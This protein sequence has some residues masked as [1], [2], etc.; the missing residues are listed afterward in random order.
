MLKPMLKMKP[1]RE[2]FK[3]LYYEQRTDLKIDTPY[4]YDFDDKYFE[5]NYDL[6][7]NYH[8]PYDYIDVLN[9]VPN[10]RC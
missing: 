9:F 3:N 10:P 5:P 7:V 2:R 6:A 1:R 8:Y 4:N